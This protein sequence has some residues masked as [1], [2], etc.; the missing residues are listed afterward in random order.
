MTLCLDVVRIIATYLDTQST[1]KFLMV[2]NDPKIYNAIR[3]SLYVNCCVTHPIQ[4]CV[5]F[6]SVARFNYHKYMLSIGELDCLRTTDIHVVNGIVN[7]HGLCVF[8]VARSSDIIRISAK[9]YK[10]YTYIC[11]N[12]IIFDLSG[13]KNSLTISNIYSYTGSNMQGITIKLFVTAV[14]IG[15]GRVVFP[16]GLYCTI[17]E[18]S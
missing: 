10:E 12:Y 15:I 9:Y 17:S 18:H 7:T 6:S 11:P 4:L 2:V 16:T 14:R 8:D 1:I 3:D 13:N 5:M